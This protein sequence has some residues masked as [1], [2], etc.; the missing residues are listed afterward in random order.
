MFYGAM[1][2]M[3]SI[4]R[5]LPWVAFRGVASSRLLGPALGSFFEMMCSLSS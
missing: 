4:V 3:V 1:K 2:V 5:Y